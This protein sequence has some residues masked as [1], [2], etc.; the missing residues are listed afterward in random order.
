MATSDSGIVT[1][2]ISAARQSKRKSAEDEHDEQRA[3]DQRR[4]SGGRCA[5]STKL[6]GR[7]MVVSISM[8]GSP[9]RISSMASSTP[10]VTSRVLPHG[11]FST[12]SMRPGPSL[13]TAS[14]VSGW[15][16][17]A[18][19][20][21]SPMRSDGRPAPRR[22][23][24]ARSVGRDDRQHVADP[25]PLVGRVDEPAGADE[26]ALARLQ[27]ARRR[28]PRRSTSITWS[29]DTSLP[30]ELL[31]LDLRPASGLDAL[32]PDRRRSPRPGTRSS[33]ARI[34]Q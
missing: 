19:S 12:M 30:L 6:A 1:T 25:E 4:A 17:V 8:P 34:F 27:D 32:A 24:S 22:T 2:L 15:W 5:S 33:R 26:P 11:S 14:P 28:G 13:I 3:Q 29:S 7:K 23:T 16:S 20:A 31:R 9:G 10:S 18:T 21:T